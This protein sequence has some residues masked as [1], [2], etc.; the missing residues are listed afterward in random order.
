MGEWNN[1]FTFQ[2]EGHRYVKLEFVHE[3]QNFF[4]DCTGE[5]LEFTKSAKFK[6]KPHNDFNPLN[7][8]Q[9]K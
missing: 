5:K 8:E 2:F 9:T 7:H 6:A 1:T 4:L 3:L